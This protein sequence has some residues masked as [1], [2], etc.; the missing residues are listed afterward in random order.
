MSESSWLKN[1]E[2]VTHYRFQNGARWTVRHQYQPETCLHCGKQQY[3]RLTHITIVDS[4]GGPGR[5]IPHIN[6]RID[7]TELK[8]VAVQCIQ[9]GDTEIP[10]HEVEM[11]DGWALEAD[12]VIIATQVPG[13]RG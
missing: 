1:E 6:R 3:C 4:A 5:V 11:A 9:D 12:G 8:K 7:L 10:V 2:S 13:P